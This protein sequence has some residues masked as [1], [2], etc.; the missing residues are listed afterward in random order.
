MPRF[1]EG[2][3]K[4]IRTMLIDINGKSQ[5]VLDD[6]LKLIDSTDKEIDMRLQLFAGEKKS[7]LEAAK[8][9][10]L[11][12]CDKFDKEIAELEILIKGA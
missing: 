10:Q 3:R 12:C 6:V 5:N 7:E 9:N 4:L 1:T 11:A 8:V 2:T